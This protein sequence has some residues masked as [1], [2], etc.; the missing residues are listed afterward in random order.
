VGQARVGLAAS[1][2]EHPLAEDGRIDQGLAPERCGR[3]G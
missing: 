2:I 3:R 1:D